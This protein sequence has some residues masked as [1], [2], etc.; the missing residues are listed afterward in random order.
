MD[1]AI[2]YIELGTSILEPGCDFA[3]AVYVGWEAI[4]FAFMWVSVFV[5]YPASAAV[6]ALTF[7]QYIV[8]GISPALA[9]PSPWN[10]ITERILGYSIVV[11]LTFLNFYAIDRFAGRFQVVVTTAKML[12]M[13]IIIATGFYYLIF[14]GWTQNL[15]NMMEGSV[16]APG[17]LT[18]AFYGGLWSYAGWDILNYG[19][20]EIEKPR[21]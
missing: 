3:Y 15:E 1:S 2:C 18:L 16:Y 6:Q 17:K 21:R 7:G 5:T 9:I 8:N 13:G 20:P 10:E 14:K 19:T 11:V 12:A 4:A